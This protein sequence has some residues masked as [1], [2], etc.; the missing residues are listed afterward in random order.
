MCSASYRLR[1]TARHTLSFVP[2]LALTLTA[3]ACGGSAPVAAP[4]A[5][6]AKTAKSTKPK[7]KSKAKPKTTTTTVAKTTKPRPDLDDFAESSQSESA[8]RPP[9][10]EPPPPQ[11]AS[12]PPTPDKFPELVQTVKEKVPKWKDGG[13]FVVRFMNE[14]SQSRLSD[15]YIAHDGFEKTKEGRTVVFAR[16][17]DGV[18]WF[19]LV[20]QKLTIGH[21]ECGKDLAL[22]SSFTTEGFVGA[23]PDTSWTM[24]EGGLC[25]LDLYAGSNPGD[26]QGKFS[27]KLVSNKGDKYL[28][29]EAG[30]LYMKAAP[31]AR[32]SPKPPA[33]VDFPY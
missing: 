32:P 18:G 31:A 21:H 6:T 11:P 23:N 24:N 1:K 25:E 29:V 19:V 9:A 28:I 27:G 30:Y 3:A 22:A 17:E 26:L 8:R 10:P 13:A 33:K 12:T 20:A 4:P 15:T 16:A 7:P 5:P 2:L 14:S